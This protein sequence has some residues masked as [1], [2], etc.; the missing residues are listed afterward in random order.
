[1]YL[2]DIEFDSRGWMQRADKL[3]SAGGSVPGRAEV[4][5]KLQAP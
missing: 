5:T 1:V 3:A 4:I 2:L